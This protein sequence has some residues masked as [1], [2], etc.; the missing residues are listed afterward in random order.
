M[1]RYVYMAG[2]FMVAMVCLLGG[3]NAVE[4]TVGDSR[5]WSLPPNGSTDYYNEWSSNKTFFIG[6][7]LGNNIFR[8]RLF[9]IGDD[10]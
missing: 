6:D 9:S 10:F 4:Y 5:G 2:F 3:A 7:Q 1:A 8:S